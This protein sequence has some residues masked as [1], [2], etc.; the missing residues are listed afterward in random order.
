M[1][2]NISLVSYLFTVLEYMKGLTVV[3]L[4]VY[5]SVPIN[6]TDFQRTIADP[7]A[8]GTAQESSILDEVICWRR[9]WC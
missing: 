6:N 3:Y 8:K 7:D 2:T 9:E 5:R 1:K 4:L